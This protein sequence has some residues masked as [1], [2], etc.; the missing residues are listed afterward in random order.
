M[1]TDLPLF[2]S[3][4][5]FQLLASVEWCL[6]NCKFEAFSINNRHLKLGS[7]VEINK[8]LEDTLTEF[9][10]RTLFSH[11]FNLGSMDIIQG[12]YFDDV[13]GRT[14]VALWSGLQQRVFDSILVILPPPPAT[15]LTN[16]S[17]MGALRYGVEMLNNAKPTE[18]EIT[19]LER[20]VN[21]VACPSLDA[22][23]LV[24]LIAAQGSK[25]LIAIPEIQNYR[26]NTLP[27][28]SIIGLSA[29]LTSQ[30][31]WI[32]HVVSIC[33]Q[34]MTELKNHDAY[35]VVHVDD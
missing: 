30:D 13:I 17:V 29:V 8:D 35:A 10:P 27:P 5:P 15:A 34:I 26:D 16:E 7:M 25:Q 6:I 1:S 2:Y 9:D 22:A 32:Q 31:V 19:F 14:P 24:S 23:D 21:I 20:I 12:G 33:R 18:K 11:G 28:R 4:V 3:Q